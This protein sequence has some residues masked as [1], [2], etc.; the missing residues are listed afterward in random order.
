MVLVSSA[1]GW[2]LQQ[3]RQG[4]QGVKLFELV[5]KCW[6]MPEGMTVMGGVNQRQSFF[7]LAHPLS[8]Y[9]L[10]HKQCWVN[11]VLSL[12]F[13]LL[14]RHT[15]HTIILTVQ[16]WC[17]HFIMLLQWGIQKGGGVQGVPFGP[18][19]IGRGGGMKLCASV[20]NCIVLYIGL[21]LSKILDPTLYYV[22]NR[23]SNKLSIRTLK[24]LQYCR[25]L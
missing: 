2:Y 3:W 7:P 23:L 1:A 18:P 22:T 8:S 13:I 4:F 5:N 9:F 20:K 6:L 21:P 15:D 25:F 11:C 12:R 17:F 16:C 10:F 19:K 14:P 24:L